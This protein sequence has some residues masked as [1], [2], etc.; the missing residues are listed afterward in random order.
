MKHA[1]QTERKA[2]ELVA[3]LDALARRFI[4]HH[5]IPCRDDLALTRHEFRVIAAI[6]HRQGCTMGELA[7]QLVLGVSGLTP[8]VDRLVDKGLVRRE[9]AEE[10]RRIVRVE[11]S[12]KASRLYGQLRAHRLR[13]ARA[14][15][16]ALNGKEQETFLRL[17]GK[18][19][20]SGLAVMCALLLAGGCAT[21]RQ[22]REVQRGERVPA[23]ERTLTAA[24]AGLSTNS[25]LTLEEAT[26]IALAY[27][28]AVALASQNLAAAA[29]QV[30]EAKAAFWP[31]VNGQAGYSQSTANTGAEPD[32]NGSRGSY[33]G[34]LN[35]DLLAYDFGKTPAAV[36]QAC[37]RQVA[38]EESL[39]SAR[40]DAAF[41]VRTAFFN[42]CQAQE[43]RQVAEEAV[44]QFQAHLD[45]VKAFAEVGRRIRYDV[46][47][48]EVDLGNAQLDLVN[49][50][51]AVATAR[52]A[53][54]RSL[55]L[56][57]EPGYQ[58]APTAPVEFAATVADMMAAARENHPA[59]RALR[60]Q[61]RAAS[62]AVDAAIADLY[63][64]LRIQA[65]YGASG[66][67]FPLVW[68]W[69]AAVQA[70]LS[71]LD[72]GQ[73]MGRIEEAVA[74]LRG[75]RAQVADREQQIHLDLSQAV[76]QLESAQNRLTLSD[77]I[78]RQAQESLDLLNERY[79]LGA[80]SSVELTDAQVALTRAR[81][82]QVKARF[83]YQS[84]VAQ[85]QHS[86]GKE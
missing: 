80:A 84:A 13:M 59:L 29:A 61:E 52:A 7:G 82:D 41:G 36:R 76:S 20:G 25:V 34:G 44:R 32:S 81:G 33:S 60:A 45:Q 35:L 31:S 85:I 48:A 77:L 43:L 40:S 75:A 2:A 56:A 66:S 70:A 21:V 26:R 63:P 58:V 10:D 4:R 37:A 53:L 71:L 51:S 69:S 86:I 64:T 62:A 9:R 72:G 1:L 30:R 23:G 65:Q 57:E 55:G 54:N 24:E 39:R 50:R 42:L 28:P 46:T 15:L 78:V 74:Q 17:I 47:K 8:V 3:Q 38:A 22:A 18:I 67:S 49:A 14:M 83:D 16:E 6:G 19:A 73:R 11:L 27:H 79:R 12:A 68:N 5:K